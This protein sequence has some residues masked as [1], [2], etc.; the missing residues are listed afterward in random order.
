MG[1]KDFMVM[2]AVLY[3]EMEIWPNWGCL[4]SEDCLSE[5]REGGG[6][7]T[8]FLY[9]SMASLLNRTDTTCA[10]SDTMAHIQL[11]CPSSCRVKNY[12]RRHG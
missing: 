5:Y 6:Y 1:R 8:H 7:A 12:C 11:S 10:L 3:E 2:T 9:S 4:P